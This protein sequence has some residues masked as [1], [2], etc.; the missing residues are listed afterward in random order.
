MIYKLALLGAC[1]SG[2]VWAAPVQITISLSG[3]TFDRGVTTTGDDTGN[4]FT[5]SATTCTGAGCSSLSNLS[6]LNS[7]LFDFVVPSGSSNGAGAVLSGSLVQSQK[8]SPFVFTGQSAFNQNSTFTENVSVTG[9]L[10][11]PS[12]LTGTLALTWSGNASVQARAATGTITLTGD[13]TTPEP[14]TALLLVLP[15]AC[16]LAIRKTVARRRASFV[17]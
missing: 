11:F 15:I 9:I 3:G 6:S 2:M 12:S 8:L 14:S 10:A 16:L 5:T 4:S 1:F 7:L 17:A 13:V